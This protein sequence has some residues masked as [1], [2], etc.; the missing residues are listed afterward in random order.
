MKAWAK[1]G[2]IGFFLVF[3]ALWIT[4]FLIGY[5]GEWQCAGVK[6]KTPCSFSEFLFAP[7]H[8]G[9]VL[10]FSWVGFFAGII[11]LNKIRKIIE[12]ETDRKI[13]PLKIAK[14]IT[15][16]MV[17]VFLIIGF[18]AFDGWVTIMIYAIIFGGFAALVSWYIG[19]KKYHR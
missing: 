17:V 4:L 8:L 7:L 19:K 14:V 11:D 15:T 13:I 12:K 6:E 1:A 5:D 3:V 9:F 18:L 16:T 10:F 2:V